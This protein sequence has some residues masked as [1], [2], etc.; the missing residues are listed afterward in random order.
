MC[1]FLNNIPMYEADNKMYKVITNQDKAKPL[2]TDKGTE[3]ERK[4]S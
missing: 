3:T 2:N 1:T 4:H